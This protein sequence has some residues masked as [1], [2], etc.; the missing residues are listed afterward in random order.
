[1][2]RSALV[3][4]AGIVAGGVA[5]GGFGWAAPA[6]LGPPR[7]VDETAAAGVD[8]AYSGDFVYAVGGGVAA[9][10]CDGD[11]KAELYLAGGSGRLRS[12]GT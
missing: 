7:F 10:D 11:G 8:H 9:F 4:L 12:T 5:I 2:R 1:M 6:A 3:V